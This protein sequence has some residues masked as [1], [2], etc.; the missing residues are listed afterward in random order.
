M[1]IS[2]MP[3]STMSYLEQHFGGYGKV[4]CL[5]NNPRTAGLLQLCPVRHI[6]RKSEHAS[7]HSELCCAN[8]NKIQTF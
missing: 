3:E 4:N 1:L 8:C 7:M 6:G 2:I 5:L